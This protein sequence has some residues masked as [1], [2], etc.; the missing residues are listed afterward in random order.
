MARYW[1]IPVNETVNKQGKFNFDLIPIMTVEC[2][3][4]A[5][6]KCVP[7]IQTSVNKL[8]NSVS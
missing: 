6:R 2:I 5:P 8:N 1:S 7:I 4:V 3:N